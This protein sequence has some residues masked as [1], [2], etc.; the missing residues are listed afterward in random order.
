MLM[1]AGLI[2]FSSTSCGAGDRNSDEH[3]TDITED[4]NEDA[5]KPD[6]EKEA[7]ELEDGNDKNDPR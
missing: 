7:D 2:S 4:A 5:D 1:A 3:K 6:M